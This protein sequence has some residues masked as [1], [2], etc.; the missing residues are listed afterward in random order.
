[1]PFL[2][3]IYRFHWL[4]TLTALAVMLVMASLSGCSMWETRQES[5]QDWRVKLSGA[6]AS[7]P[8]ELDMTAVGRGTE[9]TESGLGADAVQFASSAASLISPGVGAGL[10]GV[11]AGAWGWLRARREQQERENDHQAVDYALDS[12]PDDAKKQAKQDIAQAHK[13]R[14]AAKQRV[15]A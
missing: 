11:L 8:V 14:V 6:V 13:N 15:R 5:K 7:L 3:W 9:K 2:Y 4:W 1:M 12:L 10:I